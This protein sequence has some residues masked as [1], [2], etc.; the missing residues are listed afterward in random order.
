LVLSVIEP[1]AQLPTVTS[2][3]PNRAIAGG[4]AFVLTVNGTNFA[5]AS[6]VR[7]NGA[8]R[9]TTFVNAMQLT[10]QIPASDIAT[11]GAQAGDVA[12]TVF[13]PITAGGGGG[14]SNAI[15]FNIVNPVP[16]LNNL[17]PSNLNAG[18]PA[19]TLT[20]NGSNFANG[21][22][23]QWNNSPRP[24]TFISSTRLTA[25]ITV[26][27][28]L[29]VRNVSVIVIN[30][31]SAAGGGGASNTSTFIVNPPPNP[32]PVLVSISPN[33]TAI[34]SPS[35]TLT[36]NGNSFVSNAVVRWN[37][38][39]RATTF[40]SQT[41]LTAQIPAS[42][43][44][45]LG[46]ATVTI[47]NPA[48]PTGGGGFSNG[49]TFTINQALNPAPVLTSVTP[50]LL[51]QRSG[52]FTL[53]ANGTSF[54]P[55]SIV[56][57]NG[58]DRATTFVSA[59]QLRAEII[60]TDL[61]NAGLAQV[62]VFNP[63]SPGGGGGTSAVQSVVIAPT[64]ASASAASYRG[65]EIARESI[66]AGFGVSLATAIEVART[67]PLPTNLLGTQVSIRDSAGVT[68]L[69]PLFFVA[70]TQINYLL[71][72]Q[73]A[74][75]IAAVTVTSG[76]NKISL[77]TLNVTDVA[78]GLF[79]ANANGAGVPSAVVLR[80]R[81]DGTFTYEPLASFN[82][83]T[84]QWQPMPIELGPESDQVFLILYGTGFTNR[85]SLLNGAP[86]NV[87]AT[88][89]GISVNVPFAGAQGSLVGVDQANVPL[90]RGLRGRGEIDVSM[91]VDG[92]TTNTVRIAIQ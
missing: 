57:W 13:N 44:A 48:S 26:D 61:N 72:A 89:G 5:N 23:V 45:N 4:A 36:V 15:T 7:W 18:S 38:A 41:Q 40:V 35:F 28:L 59:T 65:N 51:M 53:T 76:D 39:D 81:S 43:V 16:V 83:Q 46:T 52:A 91:T 25:Q 88:V 79:T 80:V 17:S 6:V 29:T 34:G 71:P 69:A 73:T 63:P 31:T 1:A 2:V 56:R 60:A 74:M 49:L 75:G 54:L 20:L 84:A 87:A 92:K 85:R 62:T 50:N 14:T 27:D 66:V 12:I 32:V 21:A 22:I 68:R 78:P 77:G 64:F 33:N 19:F 67:N 82:Q 86:A 10:A 55:N 11:L 90:P 3:N 30:P 47:F 58:L 37:S 9:V 70:P 8:D 42:D 24:T